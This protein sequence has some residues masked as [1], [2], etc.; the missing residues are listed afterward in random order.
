MGRSLDQRSPTGCGMTESDVET[1]TMWRRRSVY[2]C[3]ATIN[4]TY[5]SHSWFLVALRAF[6]EVN[7]SHSNVYI[8]TRLVPCGHTNVQKASSPMRI[9]S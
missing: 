3:C 8:L 6:P 7:Q 5:P 2:D 1:S 4:K 9:Y